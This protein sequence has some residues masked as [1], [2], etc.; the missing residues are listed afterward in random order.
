M[1]P[2]QQG[3]S[4]LNMNNIKDIASL[5]SIYIDIYDLLIFEFHVH[6]DQRVRD[7]DHTCFNLGHGQNDRASSINTHGRCFILF[8]HGDCQGRSMKVAPNENCNSHFQHC[9]FNDVTS[10]FKICSSKVSISNKRFMI[11]LPS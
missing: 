8:E 7:G 10:S 3:L 11:F 6:L 4:F 1:Y 9:N 5:V 2:Y